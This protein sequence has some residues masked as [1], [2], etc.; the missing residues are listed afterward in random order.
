[1]SS[2]AFNFSIL[3]D[4]MALG[5]DAKDYK[6]FIYVTGKILQDQ[7]VSR[8]LLLNR[9]LTYLENQRNKW[10]IWSIMGSTS[11]SSKKKRMDGVLRSMMLLE[12]FEISQGND[13]GVRKKMS[14]TS[15][16]TREEIVGEI[17]ESHPH[18]FK[19]H[20][21]KSAFLVGLL[22]GRLMVIQYQ[23]RGST[24]FEKKLHNLKFTMKRLKRLY[25]EIEAKMKA[26]GHSG[27]YRGLEQILSEELLN[28]ASEDIDDDELSLSFVM[29]LNQSYKLKSSKGDDDE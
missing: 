29:G 15:K 11:A 5:R 27:T 4:I 23:R 18:F 16:I 3:R 9:I 21:Q 19:T 28:A 20:S 17:F 8:E 2:I 22:T 13:G 7:P 14:D 6:E 1:E 24:P 25:L 26:Y 12:F 10:G